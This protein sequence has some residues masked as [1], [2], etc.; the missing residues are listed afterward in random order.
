MLMIRLIPRQPIGGILCVAWLLL[1]ACSTAQPAW[2]A[3]FGQGVDKVKLQFDTTFT[4][5]S[6]GFLSSLLAHARAWSGGGH[7]SPH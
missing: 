6:P 1:T 2:V 7:F 4:A 3:E 5:T